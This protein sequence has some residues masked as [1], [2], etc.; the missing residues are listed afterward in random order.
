MGGF[1]GGVPDTAKRQLAA[2][3]QRRRRSGTIEFVNG[4]VDGDLAWLVFVERNVVE[5]VDDPEGFQRRWDLRVTEIFLRADGDWTRVHRHA[6]PLV[7]R[8]SLT[9]VAALIG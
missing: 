8:R 9:D 5:F 7:D 3:A 4:G 6:D 2:A 1:G